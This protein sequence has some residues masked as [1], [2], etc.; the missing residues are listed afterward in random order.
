MILKAGQLD[1]C[2]PH[3]MKVLTSNVSVR[4]DQGSRYLAGDQNAEITRVPKLGARINSL[5]KARTGRE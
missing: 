1:A 4:G 5:K 2:E 3:T